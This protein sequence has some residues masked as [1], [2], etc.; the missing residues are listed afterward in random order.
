MTT[1]RENN[2]S[3]SLLIKVREILLI[4]STIATLAGLSGMFIKIGNYQSDFKNLCNRTD[5]IE[6]T[7]KEDA[8]EH[9]KFRDDIIC[10][11]TDFKYFIKE[12][13]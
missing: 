3:T 13:N 2:G 5:N 12:R 7:L 10:L 1:N 9:I 11:K 6:I 8:A 4:I